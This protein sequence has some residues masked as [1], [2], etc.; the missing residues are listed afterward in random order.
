MEYY[1]QYELSQLVPCIRRLREIFE[2]ASS[3]PQ[4]AVHEKYKD[5]KFDCVSTLTPPSNL[6]FECMDI[7]DS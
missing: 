7:E 2:N 4:Q 1:T 6:P 5:A 3:H